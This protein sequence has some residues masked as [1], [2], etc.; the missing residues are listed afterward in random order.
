MSAMKELLHADTVTRADVRVHRRFG[1]VTHKRDD[2]IVGCV[3]RDVNAAGKPIWR[4]Y[5]GD[6]SSFDF[7]R[8]G[9]IAQV[10][11]LHNMQEKARAYDL[12]TRLAVVN[13]PGPNVPGSV[14]ETD[15]TGRMVWTAGGAR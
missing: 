3:G 15:S 12:I 9:A 6:I 14:G 8:T 11:E 5:A 4:A 2:S 13:T 10:I 7:T 1:W